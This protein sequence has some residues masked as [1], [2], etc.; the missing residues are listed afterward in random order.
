VP[1]GLADRADVRTRFLAQDD[2]RLNSDAH[3]VDG[4]VTAR[5]RSDNGG[6]ASLSASGYD[7]E[8][9][10]PPEAH[11]DEPRLWRYPEQRRVLAAVSGG[12]GIRETRW[13]S[14]DVEMSLGVD[15]GSTLIEQFASEAFATVDE[16]EDTDDRVVTI[17]VLGEHTIGAF[18]NLE[19]SATLADISHDEVLTPGVAASYRQRLWSFGAETEWRADHFTVSLGGVL[20]G[21]DTPESGDKTPIGAISDYGL[22]LGVSG[23]VADGV[24]VHGGVSRRS[25]FPSLRELYSGALGRFLPNPDLRAETLVGSEAGVTASGRSR[26]IQVVAFHHRLSDGIVRRSVTGPDGVSAF[27]QRVNQ[28]AVRGTGLEVLASATFGIT[29]L[30]G[31]WTWQSVKGLEADGTEVE[32]EYEPSFVGKAGV[33][34]RLPTG[35]H[36]GGEVR[37]VGAQLCE[38]PEIGALQSLEASTST[39]VSI[40]KLFRLGRGG[41][42]RRVDAT[43]SV[44]NVTDAPVFD[45]CGLPQPGRLLGIQF[46]IW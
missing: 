31:E 16:T 35:I 46:R 20:D 19:A 28:D 8:R 11:Q 21:A 34:L 44:R 43:A 12:S 17:R 41:V 36:V 27:Y 15:L 13:G 38:N 23:L 29:T 1:D 40:R 37:R 14:G 6:W 33:D 24:L 3:R 18:G 2:L 9:G 32:L 10:V 25:R 22:R 45:Q 39:D 4:F 42:L 7:V 26:E 5:Y 30:T